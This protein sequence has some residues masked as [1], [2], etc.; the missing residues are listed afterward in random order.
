MSHNSAC[1]AC[2]AFSPLAPSA[3]IVDTIECAVHTRGFEEEVDP[4]ARAALGSLRRRK[5]KRLP[6]VGA[7]EQMRPV[8]RPLLYSCVAAAQ[9]LKAV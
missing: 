7:W 1:K 3:D 4:A 2:S 6:A 5:K 8:L 9:C